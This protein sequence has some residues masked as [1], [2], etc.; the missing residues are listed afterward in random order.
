M[1]L[2]T[3]LISAGLCSIALPALADANACMDAHRS[4]QKLRKDQKLIEARE[5]L[6]ACAGA[7][8]PGMVQ[9]DCSQW[10]GEIGHEIPSVIV[11]AKDE[12]DHELTNVSVSIDGKRVAEKLDGKPIELNPGAYKFRYEK[13]KSEPI[14]ADVVLKTGVANRVVEVVFP[15]GLPERK[16][17]KPPLVTWILVGTGS[18]ALL[19]FT[20]FGL[21]GRSEYNDKENECGTSGCPSSETDS[22]RTKFLIADISLVISLA[23]FAGA[24]YFYLTRPYETVPAAAK[25]EAPR[26]GIAVTPR[27]G[28]AS[29]TTRF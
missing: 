5:Q 14:E 12:G 18:A 3:F 17:V 26:I 25:R 19:S 20:Y 9:S 7:K 13:S 16:R 28:F 24:G 6:V 1:K 23:S 27:G 2:Q 29:V 15:G 8:C 11:S 21:R 22:I 4:A 10:L